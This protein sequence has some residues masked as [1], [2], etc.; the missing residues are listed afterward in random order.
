LAT[1]PRPAV[2]PTHPAIQYVPGRET[3]H[4]PQSS[5]EVNAWSYTCTPPYV[6]R[7]R[8]LIKHGV[9]LKHRDKFAFKAR[10]A[11]EVSSCGTNFPSFE[12]IKR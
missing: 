2:V 5:T 7:A 9:V 1:T 12:R 11:K 10:K 3:S 4:S 8:C 6:F